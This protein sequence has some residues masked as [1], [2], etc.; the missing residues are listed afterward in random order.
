MTIFHDIYCHGYLPHRS[1]AV[2]VDTICKLKLTSGK[3]ISS[4]HHAS[5]YVVLLEIFYHD[6]I[7]Y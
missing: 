7:K 2:E 4:C 1:V 5:D 3:V 6:Y